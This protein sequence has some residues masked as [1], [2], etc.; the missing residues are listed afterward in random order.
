MRF[1]ATIF[2]VFTLLTH[3]ASAQTGPRHV[4][5]VIDDSGF[6]QD[7]MNTSA[8]PDNRDK[9]GMQ[10][11]RALLLQKLTRLPRGDTIT[12]VSVALPQVIW[13]GTSR[14]IGRRDNYTLGDFLVTPYNG[15]ANFD[16]VMQTVD[17][18]ISEVGQPVSEIIFLSSLIH[19]GGNSRDFTTCKQPTV[20]N[21]TFPESALDAL[22]RQMAETNTQATFYWV[23]DL[24]EAQVADYFRSKGLPYRAKACKEARSPNTRYGNPFDR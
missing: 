3:A 16:A 11:A 15:C 19:T 1:I 14:E 20:A 12:V 10:K 21:M 5:V 7:H 17:R 13:Q 23:I 22:A 2:A 9:P 4:V 24:V 6:V 8:D 18:A